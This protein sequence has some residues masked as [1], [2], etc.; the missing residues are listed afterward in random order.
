[1]Q[2][3]LCSLR[4]TVGNLETE[5]VSFEEEMKTSISILGESQHLKGNVEHFKSQYKN[6]IH[7]LKDRLSFLDSEILKLRSDLK[8]C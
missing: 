8:K 5:F 4:N 1:M 3:R 7:I 6:E 2:L